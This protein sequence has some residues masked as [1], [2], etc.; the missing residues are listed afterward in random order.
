M[1][2]REPKNQKIAV[3]VL[4]F[5]IVMYFWYSRV[6]SSYDSQIEAK[7]REFETVTTH[8]KNV[9]MKA[10][11]LDA[12]RQEDDDLVGR[13]HEIEALLPEVKM[14]PSIL[15]QLHT[16]SSLTG[17]KITRIQPMPIKS[18]QFYNIASFEVEMT[19]TYHDF[20]SFISYVANFPFI[21]N[22]SSMEIKAHNV[23][24]A[25]SQQSENEKKSQEVGK[26]QE[27]ITST[28]VLSTF[29]VK[30]EERLKELSL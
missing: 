15:V 11:S 5:L 7:S 22:V 17:S 30:E 21:A 1:D 28:F 20:G 12:L 6:Y 10:K 24:I 26:K 19:G 23:A 18:E 2:F 9:E 14:I 27:T 13:Y 29:F 4:A 16:A 25:K 8:L 3:A